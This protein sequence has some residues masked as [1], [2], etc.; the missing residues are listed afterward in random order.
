MLLGT[1][2]LCGCSRMAMWASAK[3]K[4]EKNEKKPAHTHIQPSTANVHRMHTKNIT[5]MCT[6]KVLLPESVKYRTFSVHLIRSVF[7]LDKN[8]TCI[9][10]CTMLYKQLAHFSFILFC[11]LHVFSAPFAYKSKNR[12]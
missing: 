5:H 12:T 11:H 10:N 2:R 1:V 6:T 8:Y 3:N 9:Y 4:T 7:H